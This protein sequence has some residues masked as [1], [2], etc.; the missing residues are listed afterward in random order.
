MKQKRSDL[1]LYPVLYISEVFFS[2]FQTYK[3]KDTGQ[4][5]SRL[6][7]F[8]TIAWVQ[9]DNRL[10]AVSLFLENQWG[11]KERKTSKRASGNAASR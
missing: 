9:H 1:Y 6:I 10:G 4:N 11:R 8:G 5:I 3:G 2:L 7:P